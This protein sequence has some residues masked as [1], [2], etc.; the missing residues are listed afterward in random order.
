MNSYIDSLRVIAA[1]SVVL[2]HISGDGFDINSVDFQN[3][4]LYFRYIFNTPYSIR[5][6][7]LSRLYY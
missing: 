6:F 1:L 7:L 4:S 3:G 2:L 5:F